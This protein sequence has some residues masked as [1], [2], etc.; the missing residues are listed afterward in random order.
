MSAISAWLDH[1]GL[2]RYA[3]AFDENAVDLDVVS[4]LTEVDLERMG[5][6]LG[7]R[8]RILR[9]ISISSVVSPA[10]ATTQTVPSQHLES[11]KRQLTMFFCDLVGSTALAV[12]LDP[13][14]LSALI[15]RFQSTCTAIITHMVAMSRSS[16]VTGFSPISGIRWPMR[17]RPKMRCMPGSIWSR[18]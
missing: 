9:A 2:G 16:W 5:V 8:K 1:L 10:V 15:R 6:A 11:E 13:E 7:H 17:T 18:S 3:A 14:D 4:E 12:Q